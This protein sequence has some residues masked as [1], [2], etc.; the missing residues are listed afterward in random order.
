M[1]RQSALFLQAMWDQGIEKDDIIALSKE[2]MRYEIERS[3]K[4]VLHPRTIWISDEAKELKRRLLRIRERIDA[5]DDPYQLP[6]IADEYREVMGRIQAMQ[7]STVQALNAGLAISDLHILVRQLFPLAFARIKERIIYERY[8]L[9]VLSGRLDYEGITLPEHDDLQ[10]WLEYYKNR[11]YALTRAFDVDELKGGWA[12]EKRKVVIDKRLRFTQFVAAEPREEECALMLGR[13]DFGA[14]EGGTVR[15][16][17]RG[18]LTNLVPEDMAGGVEKSF[19]KHLTDIAD[20]SG[21]TDE[22]R[23]PLEIL[24][25]YF[26]GKKFV[27]SVEEYFRFINIYLVIKEFYPRIERGSC[28]Y[29]GAPLYQGICQKCGDEG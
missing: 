11:L 5:M 9:L 23:N 19:E 2:N 15:I 7:I 27:I 10:D 18:C 21:V 16:Y 17:G 1:N 3:M 25:R 24:N 26:E 6:E 12:Y 4:G 20:F 8:R 28:I 13:A 29:C 22:D 14:A